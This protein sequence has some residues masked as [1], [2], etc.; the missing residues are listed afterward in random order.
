MP[1]INNV[2]HKNMIVMWNYLKVFARENKLSEEDINIF[3][4]LKLSFPGGYRTALRYYTDPTQWSPLE[5]YVQCYLQTRAI[6]GDPDIYRKCGRSAAKYKSFENWQQLARSVSGPQAALN[7]LP[8]IFPDWNDTKT[9]ELVRPATFDHFKQQVKATLKITFHPHIDPCDDYC[10]D[11][12]ILGLLEAMP[13]NYPRHIFKPWETLPLGQAEQLFVQY[14]P[15][16]LFSGRFFKHLDLQPVQKDNRLYL[17]DP[18]TGKVLEVGRN[19]ILS[20]SDVSGKPVFLGQ[21]KEMKDKMNKDDQ[22]G[23]LIIKTI[24][25]QGEEV[26]KEGVI[27]AAP[28]FLINYTCKELDITKF[29]MNFGSVFVSKGRLLNEY[30]K[31]NEALR[32]EVD[33]KNVAYEKIQEYADHLEEMV[34]ERTAELNTAYQTLK[35]TQEE[36]VK[37]EVA[38]AE[39]EK[40]LHMEKAMSGGLAHE[41]RNALMPAAIQLR[42]LME[43]QEQQSAFDLLSGKSGS[44]LQ[45]IIKLENEYNLPQEKINQEIIP[46][47]REIND[48]IKDINNTTQEIS[49]GVGKGLGLIDLFRTYSKTQEM[50]RGID[51]VDVEKIARD[52]GE[53]YKK[54][55]TESG[56]TYTVNV[57][58]KDPT[59][60]GD[61][62]HIESIIKNLVLNAKDALEKAEQK[63]ITVTIARVFKAAVPYLRIEVSDTGEGI[64]E[65]Q[66]KKIFQAFYTTKSAKGTGLGLSIVKRMVEIYEGSIDIQSEVGKGAK[67]ILDLMS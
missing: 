39:R 51:Q 15:V 1:L 19:V 43:Y 16:R 59:I 49:M 35:D 32:K 37:E 8:H 34:Q 29:F 60:T 44:L 65:D 54:R 58:D 24:S 63:Q 56:I 10:S 33:E 14:D 7:M 20:P 45:Q 41:G 66:R 4:A 12:H 31:A 40:E 26:C 30:F 5:T 67:F 55:L 22:V 25:F 48:V 50:T 42:R 57:I 18:N 3:A 36:L 11:P 38:K 9:A 23:T 53:T 2:N 21:Y 61:Y 17:R 27:M 47:F 46:I 64:P 62:L 28:Y 6:T 13:T 52:L